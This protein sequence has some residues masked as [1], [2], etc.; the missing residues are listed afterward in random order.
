MD[1][2]IVLFGI[3]TVLKCCLRFGGTS[4]LKME[5]GYSSETSPTQPTSMLCKPKKMINNNY[6]FGTVVH[7]S[8]QRVQSA[9]Y[10][11]IKRLEREAEHT[12]A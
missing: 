1:H 9:L 6:E 8:F 7:I 10:V 3:C 2:L 12:S 5:A 11:A 4:T